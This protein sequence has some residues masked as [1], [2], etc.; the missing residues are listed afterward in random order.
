M[1]PPR[2]PSHPLAALTALATLPLLACAHAPR[3]LESP[4]A[5]LA[6]LEAGAQVHAVVRYARC[7]LSVEGRPQPAPDVVGGLSVVAFE[8]FSRGVVRNER[9]YTAVSET[10]LIVHPRH[11]PVQNYARLRI[12]ED[13]EVEVTAKYLKPPALEVVMDET[14]TCRL[15]EGVQLYSGG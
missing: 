3:R 11:G 12:Y 2:R 6:A 4:A 8:H 5:L 7:G 1:R 10:R 9:A 13:G 15:G 14:F